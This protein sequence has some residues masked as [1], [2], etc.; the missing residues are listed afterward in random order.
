M[1]AWRLLVALHFELH[2]QTTSKH[3]TTGTVHNN[4]RG[5]ILLCCSH[6]ANQSPEYR[7]LQSAVQLVGHLQECRDQQQ[8]VSMNE[9]SCTVG[10]LLTQYCQ[11]WQT[12]ATAL[13][14]STLI[15]AEPA[16]A[17]L[18]QALTSELRPAISAAAVA[19][20]A[21]AC[22]EGCY[23][24]QRYCR[25]CQCICCTT[26]TLLPAAMQQPRLNSAPSAAAAVGHMANICI[27]WQ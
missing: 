15:V 5:G 12:S 11:Q 1:T 16:A 8:G 4:R 13:Q 21:A 14:G 20:P 9:A 25:T 2:T 18:G 17:L 19:Q 7:F 10:L 27:R 24:L 26:G 23:T 6:I 3:T 22:S